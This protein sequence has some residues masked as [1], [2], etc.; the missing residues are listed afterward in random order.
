MISNRTGDHTGSVKRKKVLLALLPYWNPMIPA[1][2]IAHLKGFLQKHGYRVKT[3]DVIVEDESQ[4]IYR[5]YS[6]ALK[7]FVPE[8]NRGNFFNMMHDV[9]QNHM[10]A[11]WHYTD[12]Q[13]YIKL[14]KLLIFQAYYVELEVPDSLVKKL[15][16]LLDE[17]YDNLEAYFLRLIEEE[18]PGVLG[19]TAYKGTLPASMFVLK[20]VKERF[21]HIM[22]VMGGG[23]FADTHAVGTPNYEIL[24]KETE[25]Y[26]DKI[27]I[28]QGELLFLKLLE[29]KL[30]E[31]RRVLTRA[32]INGKS[33]GFSEIDLPDYSDFDLQRYPYLVATG[34]ASCLYQ[35]SF[36]NAAKFWG[37]YRQKDVKQTVEDMTTLHKKYGNQLFFMT[38]S[39][40]NPIATE[41]ARA[42]IR[43]DVAVYY[44]SYFRV[45]DAAASIENTFLWRRGGLY[46]VRM[47]TESGSQ[48]ILDA[49]D[50]Q[51][52]VPQIRNAVTGLASAGIKTTTYWVIGHPG[53]TEEDFQKTLDLIAELKDYIYQ[54]E[55][56]PFLY[57]F[58]GQFHSGQWEDERR[59]MYHEDVNPML[60]FKSWTLNR[61]PSRETIYRRIFRFQNHCRELGIPNPYSLNQHIKAD[62]RWHRLHKNAAP[63]ML[64]FIRRESYVDECKNVK[65]LSLTYNT[66]E[67]DDG[68]DF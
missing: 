10:M 23:I 8:S 3:V 56:N 33:L 63:P 67:E 15:N 17:F 40:L 14:V 57:H 61:E 20:L 68:F 7:D 29:G 39:L 38:D 31:D 60:V 58:T 52:T 42:F 11:H 19:L 35:C 4:R 55:C 5:E 18:K 64:E 36:C 53:E 62:E 65:P 21:P 37:E 1:N 6:E 13:E 25:P 48:R 66:R 26:L 32:D 9:L 47:G 28:G 16:R 12:K 59:P 41:L 27:I 2:G 30:P 24:L 22:T 34:S 45:D 51:I 43:S 46:R 49:M 44:D 50:K 54:A